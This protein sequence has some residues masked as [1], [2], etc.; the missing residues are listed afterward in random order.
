MIRRVSRGSSAATGGVVEAGHDR[1]V[2]RHPA[3]EVGKRVDQDVERAVRL[4][5]LAVDVR[6]QG[7]RRRQLEERSIAL[8]GLDDHVLAGAEARVAAERAEPAA[9]HRRRIEAGALEHPRH[10][11]RRRRL[12][13]RA[14]DRDA[15]AQAHELGEH[16][17][18]RNDRHVPRPR[19][20]DFGV[21][22]GDGRRDDD[23]VGVADVV[24]VVSDGDAH[25]KRREPIGDL[26][27][28]H[29]GSAH[30][31]TEVDEQFGDAAHANAANPDEVHA[32]RPA[33]HLR[34]PPAPAVD[35]RSAPP[36]PAAPACASPGSC[37]PAARDRATSPSTTSA[38]V[39][40]ESPRL[41]DHGRPTRVGD[42]PRVLALMVVGRRR[43]R[44]EHG[45][46]SCRGQLGER[47]RAGARNH[48]IGRRHFV[49][50]GIQRTRR[51]APRR[52]LAR[53]PD[54]PDP[55]RA[56]PSGG[57]CRALESAAP[58]PAPPPPWPR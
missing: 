46:S 17:G 53:S 20:H 10:H 55:G 7:D 27:A 15:R 13:V 50:H 38:S 8:V 33:Q 29:V 39:E 48:E 26:R 2:E 43:K 52:P 6:E 1:S 18:A 21:V 49:G 14:G 28:T 40:P 3:G 4:H 54:E 12:A 11:R 36:R 58:A 57:R 34:P 51:P 44:H 41:V 45:R 42:D 32:P 35:R 23:D 24:G 9:D 25:A 47:R 30:R 19:G 5:V 31:V 16:L 56:R 22:R 37:R